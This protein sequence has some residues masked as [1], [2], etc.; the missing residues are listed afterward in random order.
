MNRIAAQRLSSTMRYSERSGLSRI[1]LRAAR[2]A[3]SH[4]VAEL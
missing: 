2:S 3:P 4:S 1:V